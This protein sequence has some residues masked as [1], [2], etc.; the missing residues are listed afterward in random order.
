MCF[1]DNASPNTPVNSRFENTPT[2][3][4]TSRVIDLMG[5]LKE[6]L[7]ANLPHAKDLDGR[8]ILPGDRIA[9]PDRWGS[10]VWMNTARILEIVRDTLGNVTGLLVQG[11]EH[12]HG[13]KYFKSRASIVRRLDRVVLI[14]STNHPR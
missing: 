13:R 7:A 5:A 9:Y 10:S 3:Q 2:V 4:P 8:V 12:L 6:S 1:A 11:T 14:E